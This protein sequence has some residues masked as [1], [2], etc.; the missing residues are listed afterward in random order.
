MVR[1]ILV[2][3]FTFQDCLTLANIVDKE[4]QGPIL[5]DERMI[6]NRNGVAEQ[7]LSQKK[8]DSNEQKSLRVNH[9][10]NYVGYKSKKVYFDNMDSNESF[11]KYIIQGES[12][13]ILIGSVG[14]SSPANKHDVLEKLAK[15]VKEAENANLIES[16][17]ILMG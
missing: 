15:E 4:N 1:I 17:Q 13:G 2:I 12:V 11:F 7:N 16:C 5:N 3:T 6:P 8:E 9:C 14:I 10:K